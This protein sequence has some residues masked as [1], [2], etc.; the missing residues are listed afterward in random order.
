MLESKQDQSYQILLILTDG[1]ILD[2]EIT[3]DYLVQ[4]APHPCSVIIVG[5]G[6]DDFHL[7]EELDG[8]KHKIK[9]TALEEISRDIV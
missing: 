3:K 6:D 7:M 2:M 4:L 8:D 5:V 1:D 9:N